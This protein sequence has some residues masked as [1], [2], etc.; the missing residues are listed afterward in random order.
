MAKCLGFCLLFFS[1]YA[2]G[3]AINFYSLENGLCDLQGKHFRN[4]KTHRQHFSEPLCDSL[5]QIFRGCESD[6][7]SV[8]GFCFTES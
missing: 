4:V 8:R 5:G 1:V 6:N 7:S 3:L 2:R